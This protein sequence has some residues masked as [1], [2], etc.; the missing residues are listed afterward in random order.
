[1]YKRQYKFY[2][3]WL[4]IA[5]EDVIRYLKYFTWLDKASIDGLGNETK[6]NPGQR[7]AQQVLAEEITKIVHGIDLLN[8]AKSAS[9][10]LFGGDMKG[11]TANEIKDIFDDVPS[12]NFP[13][14]DIEEGNI[15]IIDFLVTNQIIIGKADARRLIDSGGISL[16]NEKVSQTDLIITKT[17]FIEEKFI[18]VRKGKKN[19]FLINLI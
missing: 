4:N 7:K 11:L 9:Q 10:I 3:F 18:V 8:K 12:S 19:Y 1:M 13:I 16:N 6:I 15:N 17:L 14:K 2:Q 5:D